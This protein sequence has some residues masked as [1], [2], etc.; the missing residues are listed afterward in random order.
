MCAKVEFLISIMSVCR[1]GIFL[2][3]QKKKNKADP[4][5]FWK[6]FR[7]KNYKSTSGYL[8]WF[9]HT[10]SITD[11]SDPFSNTLPTKQVHRTDLIK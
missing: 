1:A 9:H 10:L 6:A 5:I 3:E 7:G 2:L 8:N 4:S 11:Q